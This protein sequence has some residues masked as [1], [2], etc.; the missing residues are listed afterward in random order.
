MTN[1]ELILIGWN[2]AEKYI[3]DA[4]DTYINNSYLFDIPTVYHDNITT[5]INEFKGIVDNYN[6]IAKKA[7]IISCIYYYYFRDNFVTVGINHRYENAF[8]LARFLWYISIDYRD[9]IDDIQDTLEK[10]L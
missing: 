5:A 9:F 1:S 6:A 2:F 4:V 3:S 8:D 7:E 10:Y